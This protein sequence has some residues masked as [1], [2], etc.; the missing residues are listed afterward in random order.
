MKRIVFIITT[1]ILTLFCHQKE[2]K[3][4]NRFNNRMVALEQ[5]TPDL[6]NWSTYA[7]K[8]V[9]A[10]NTSHDPD[11]VWWLS[12]ASWKKAE[13][14][15]TVYDP[16]K[17]NQ[18][19]F[20]DCLCSSGDQIRGI[21]EVFYQTKP[22]VDNKN[23]TK[24]EV[25]E[26]HR[27]AI[28]HIRALVG[29]TTP[30][31]QIQK[32]HCLFVR[33]LWGNE[34]S[35]TT[36]WDTKYPGTV[37]SAAGPCQ[38]SKNAHCGATFIPDANDQIPYLPKNYPLCS[39]EPGAEGIFPGPKSNIPWSI[40]F[41]R[42]FC[43]TLATEGFWGG[44][45]GPW[46]HREKFGFNFWDADPKN[47]NNNAVLRAKW[48]GK[49]MPS[50]YV[51]N[52]PL[53]VSQQVFINTTEILANAVMDF[54]ATPKGTPISTVI[55][56]KNNGNASLNLANLTVP[57]GFSIVTPFS[58]TTLDADEETTFEVRLDATNTIPAGSKISF[59]N[60]H[61]LV[62]INVKADV[63]GATPATVSQQVFVNTTEILANAVMDFGATPKGTPI[64][65][66]IKIKNNGNA[67]LNLTNLTVPAGFSILTP[68]AQTTLK[69]GEE[70]TFEVRL[71]ATNTIPAGSKISFS[72]GHGLVNINVKADVQG[73][74]P[75]PPTPTPTGGGTPPTVFIDFPIR[76]NVGQVTENQ[77]TISWNT[78]QG[79]TQYAVERRIVGTN[80]FER[81]STVNNAN[82]F[83]DSNLSPGEL[84]EYRIVAL[85]SS[86]PQPI[87]ASMSASTTPLA[88]TAKEGVVCGRGVV[89][90]S[91]QANTSKTVFYR[92]YE[93][94][95]DTKAL[96]ESDANTFKTPIIAET[97]TYYV[98]VVFN[99]RESKRT[100]V[101]AVV[102]AL[103][104]S[105][106]KEGN[107]IT[108]CEKGTIN[109]EKVEGTS[110]Q[111]LSA[112][113]QEIGKG[114]SLEIKFSGTY[115]LATQKDGCPQV[116]APIQVIINPLPI[117]QILQGTSVKFCREGIIQAQSYSN[118][119]YEWTD[120]Q[121]VILGKEATLKISK[122]GIY[123][124]K[125]KQ[126]ECESKATQI[127]VEIPA[128]ITL[129]KITVNQSTI[130][131]GETLKMELPQIAGAT[132]F[133]SGAGINPTLQTNKVE[134]NHN[135]NFQN[136]VYQVYVEKEGCHSDTVSVEIKFARPVVFELK[137][138]NP[139]CVGSKDGMIEIIDNSGGLQFSV[140]KESLFNRLKI[141]N[142]DKGEYIITAK[143]ESGCEKT[144][145]VIL[146][147]PPDFK[148]S[149]GEDLRI[150]RFVP[151]KL[152]ATGAV[153][154]EWSPSIGL[155]NPNLANPKANPLQTT[156]YTV[157]GYNENGCIR[158]D[159]VIV[160]VLEVENLLTSKV[161]S[162]NN[163]GVNDFWQIPDIDKF[164]DNQF[165][166]YN[167]LGQKVYESVN[168]KN[169]WDGKNLEDG[170][171][172]YVLLLP[173][174]K[175]MTGVITVAR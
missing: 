76:I 80:T 38:G 1:V 65:T 33:A 173:E 56:I 27:I 133:W 144:Q 16:T 77:I 11:G 58:Q 110:Y 73:G 18:K 170:T 96:Q 2:V 157:K 105:K 134:I 84:Y 117:A 174:N 107:R 90:L 139:N 72:N 149:A 3:T 114:E 46:F 150:S 20:Y 82:T 29:Y 87:P 48:G 115:H 89:N 71:D 31:R 54:G 42:A 99:G 15:G 125:T 153:R 23:P 66:V 95:N 111:W 69:A 147:D 97:T 104:S 74:T 7:T 148:V 8:P 120:A 5:Y 103:P 160:T 131:E 126:N 138:Q 116:S 122:S 21:R 129:P 132:Y 19:Q 24:A 39:T 67:S 51:K 85:T 171:Y 47:N 137:T 57:A 142:L 168:Y 154:Y 26:W 28:N 102:K 92:W 141:N 163:D 146:N 59:S 127:K 25:D 143:N 83:T 41:S 109:A 165:V 44:H 135:L 79:T 164:P 70:T 13:W 61:G 37:G 4:D 52:A 167:R 140:N 43:S 98:A 49:L 118:M 17:M 78:I 36:M 108:F 63:Q 14:D 158:T 162:P 172:Y 124:L 81:I 86:Q 30:D 88:P 136:T 40:K 75:P 106:I 151:E 64:S 112:D 166:V 169:N 121:G 62:S 6:A 155:D 32:D 113:L 119:S 55:K 22:F 145:K 101:N 128:I 35:F 130:C 91:A 45:T 100:A 68:F 123:I 94:E 60:G 10:G 53:K 93:K 156:T 9:V 152:N 34:R 161:L 12:A 159:E 50:L 175:Q